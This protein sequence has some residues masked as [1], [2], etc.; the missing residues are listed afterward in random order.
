MCCAP[1]PTSCFGSPDGWWAKACNVAPPP[2]GPC[3]AFAH[4]T[5]WDCGM[6]AEVRP[7]KTAA[8]TALA[9]SFA[10][11]RRRLPGP[12][13]AGLREEAFRQFDV[14]GLPHRRVEEWKYT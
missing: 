14:A 6:N 7:M 11:A 13:V 1:L 9:A 12:A 5:V 8:E 10:T 3:R 4:P 2:R